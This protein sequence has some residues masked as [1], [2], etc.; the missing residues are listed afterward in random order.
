MVRPHAS[1]NGQK[2][3]KASIVYTPFIAAVIQDSLTGELNLLFAKL[4]ISLFSVF[5][6]YKNMYLLCTL[7]HQF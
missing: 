7:A 6:R 2:P 3:K 4:A 1:C 5:P